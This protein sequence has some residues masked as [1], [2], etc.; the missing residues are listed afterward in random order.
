MYV[1]RILVVRDVQSKLTRLAAI[2]KLRP[3]FPPL[4]PLQSLNLRAALFRS[5]S[6]L[7]KN[8]AL[9]RE[10]VLRKTMLDEC[11]GDRFEEVLAVF[12]TAVL[13]KV[14][15]AE[16][17]EHKEVVRKLGI[18]DSISKDEQRSILPLA[19]AHRASLASLLR[20][21]QV[22]KS[23][24]EGFAQTLELKSKHIE[25]RNEQL[26]AASEDRIYQEDIGA[27]EAEVL[28]T[29]IRENWLGEA[30]WAEIAFR[31]RLQQ[32]KDPV[33]DSAFTDIFAH[34]RN[35]NLGCIE[36]QKEKGLLED[37]EA[38]I[39][40]QRER[41]KRWIQFREDLRIIDHTSD[42][43]ESAKDAGQLGIQRIDLGFKDHQHLVPGGVSPTR[44][45]PSKDLWT[46][47]DDVPQSSA[48][49]G[50][51]RFTARLQEELVN[52]ARSKARGGKG[53]REPQKDSALIIG[54]EGSTSANR[55]PCKV[56][57]ATKRNSV[58]G[59]GSLNKAAI[60]GVRIPLEQDQQQGTSQIKTKASSN[61]Q[62]PSE[63]DELKQ[64][65]SG[66]PKD[67]NLTTTARAQDLTTNPNI[68]LPSRISS[69]EAPE[70]QTRNMRRPTL[71]T[72]NQE[73]LAEAIVL[74][75]TQD[76]PS[77]AKPR[78]SL[79]E[80]TR[81]S[82]AFS[83]SHNIHQTM[84]MGPPPPPSPPAEDPVKPGSQTGPTDFDSRSTL[85][86]RTR[87]S[88]S[89]LPATSQRT[90]NS[91]YKPQCS[92][93]YPTDQF[94]TPKKQQQQESTDDGKD[95]TPREELFT[96]EADYM[97]VFKSRPKIALS[98]TISPSM[99]AEGLSDLDEGTDHTSNDSPWGSSPLMRV[100]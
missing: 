92:K 31:G 25:R 71:E 39:N 44:R 53:W 100:R 7:K 86:E 32:G 47:T 54:D 23:R 81:M 43:R 2:Q 41:L 91:N 87:Q 88:M 10:V 14:V 68:M 55:N 65:S 1:L 73:L 72:E 93:G 27:P 63:D 82:M 64:N 60:D 36:D 34:V 94:E 26:K 45:A 67:R 22:L 61:G 98:P 35:G 79:A 6:E 46:P 33:L 85:L 8:G 11:T 77:P 99:G 51:D 59:I 56:L 24:Y 21:K 12:S 15:L 57:V 74:S 29:Q 3:F 30:R 78:Q 96:Q 40:G 83:S 42:P 50:Y 62:R 58:R 28:I 13:R 4:E 84:M 75:V 52:V 16:N 37:L 49:T 90:R 20:R 97:S 9:G 66:T 70:Q 48:S 5:L 76:A 19:C 80:R 69:P 89:M 95:S 17:Y 18:T 38:R